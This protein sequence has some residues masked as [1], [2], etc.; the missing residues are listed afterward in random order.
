M[1]VKFCGF[2]RE[3]DVEAAADLG[4]SAVGFIFHPGSK[5]CVTPERA[6]ALGKMLDGSGIE[7]VGVFVDTETDDIRRAA[8]VA[9]LD[10]LQVY[11]G[12]HRDELRGFRKIIFARRI[13]GRDDLDV[14]GAP[15]GDELFLLDAYSDDAFGGTGVA[16]NW[17]HLAGFPHIGKT[18]VAGGINE[19][20]VVYLARNVRPC[21]V[22]V[23]SGIEEAP[24]VK[25]K[26]KMLS[27]MKNLQEALRHEGIA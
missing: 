15:A 10:R 16:F 20:N 7:R 3:R 11:S 8:E 4:V 13:R 2:T 26:E 18:I 17:E 22:D 19:N 21:G 23:S 5:R 6:A 27:F 9:G 1:F 14:T 25:S 12:N 24:G